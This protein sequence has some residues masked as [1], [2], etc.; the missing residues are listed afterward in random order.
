M[1]QAHQLIREFLTAVQDGCGASMVSVFV[2]TWPGMDDPIL[3]HSGDEP[4]V[5]ELR[6][7][8][9]A[10]E[11]V[12]RHAQPDAAGAN[13]ALATIASEVAGGTLLPIPRVTSLWQQVQLPGSGADPAKPGRRAAD[14]QSPPTTAGWPGA[15]LSLRR[16]RGRAPG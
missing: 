9:Q 13:T 1:W 14:A 16:H 15:A 4:A 11:F 12:G 2:P 7:V 6:N 10:F 8:E 3:M 5:P